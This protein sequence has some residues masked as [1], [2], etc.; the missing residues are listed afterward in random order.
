MPSLE[1]PEKASG[2]IEYMADLSV[3][4][5]AHAKVVRSPLPHARIVS[6]DASEA[7]ATPGVVCVLTRDE[8][9]ADPDVEEVY[10]FVYRDAPPWPWTRCGT[11]ATSSRWW[12]PT[13]STPRR[14]PPSS[15]TWSTRSCQR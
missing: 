10:G 4:N 12:S 13:T 2:R 11:R 9:R 5:M 15:W 8:V 6:T 7:R 14:P 1:A 3:P